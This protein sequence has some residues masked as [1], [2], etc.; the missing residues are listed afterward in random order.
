M[1]RA[2]SSSCRCRRT[3]AEPE[4]GFGRYG[5][6]MVRPRSY[7]D[8]ALLDAAIEQ[9]WVGGYRGSS[10]GDV[11]ERSGV[12][13]SSLYQAYGSKWELFLAAFRRYCDRRI[14]FVD[15]AFAV[16]HDGLEPAVSA[17]FDAVVA[18]CAAHPDR[19]GCLLLN[20]MA[21][22]GDDPEVAAI[23]GQTI[24]GME[25]AVAHA[26]ARVD[27]RDARDPAVAETAAGVVALSQSM[28]HLSR[29]GRDLG[30]LRRMGARAAHA[31]AV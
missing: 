19:R 21:E 9:F 8:E 11:A 23:A 24:R 31:L 6:G 30:E 12:G 15:D 20:A 18:D 25:A 1:R 7:D 10:I 14:A 17:F 22:L 29:I 4:A 26:I 3:A 16:P 5:E 13:N 2:G 28:I 27:G